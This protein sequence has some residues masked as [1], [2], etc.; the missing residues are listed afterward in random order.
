MFA[1]RLLLAQ[2]LSEQE[3][4]LTLLGLC[5][6]FPS[7]RSVSNDITLQPV[8]YHRRPTVLKQGFYERSKTVL[9]LRVNFVPVPQGNS[10]RPYDDINVKYR[11]LCPSK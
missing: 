5:G 1:A 7:P 4:R 3:F 10:C 6:F 8:D 2:E 9:E 11:T